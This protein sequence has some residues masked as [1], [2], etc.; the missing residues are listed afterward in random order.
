MSAGQSRG[1]RGYQHSGLAFP[2]CIS[3]LSA[4]SAVSIAE[5][6]A[7]EAYPF[8]EP[9]I[10]SIERAILLPHDIACNISATVLTADCVIHF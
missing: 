9:L 4:V 10:L 1:Q 5:R 6:V 3:Q 7:K 8:E 2:I